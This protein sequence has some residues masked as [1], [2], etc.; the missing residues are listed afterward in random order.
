MRITPLT[1]LV[2]GST[3]KGLAAKTMAGGALVLLATLALGQAITIDKNGNNVTNG[4]NAPVDRRYA[5]IKPT[6]VALPAGE[7]NAKTKL[8]LIR[9]LQADRGFAMRPFP[10]GHKGL[11]LEANGKMAPTGEAYQAMVVNEGLSAK[12]GE[13]LLITDVKVEKSRIILQLNGGPDPKHRFLRHIQI[14]TGPMMNPAV[15]DPGQEPIGSRLTLTFK[16]HVPDLTGK[17][18]EALLEP[19]ISFQV[20]TPLQAFTDTLPPQLK[21]AILDH[22]VLVG[23]STDMVLFA[24][25]QPRKKVR[26]MDGQMPFEE[27]IYGLP[28]EDVEFVRINGNRVIRVEVAKVG[29]PPQIF[30]KDEVEG[31]MRTDGT[32]LEPARERERKVEM[33]DVKRDPD[34]QAPAA[35]PSLRVP[36]ETTT[37]DSPNTGTSNG[38]VGV[39]KPVQF[40]E[41]KPDD[42]PVAHHDEPA[43]ETPPADTK[44]AP[45]PAPADKPREGTQPAQPTPPPTNQP[46]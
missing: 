6:T 39:M 42:H 44:D 10:K 38:R 45:A 36:G 8:E 2:P 13:R 15:Q 43:P 19:L 40:P 12:P 17:Q 23:M 4:Q 21:A 25:G 7:I 41:Q 3:R 34:T 28:P 32:P 22:T 5:P 30:D 1:G 11:M 18:V 9:Y 26:E 24:K 31:L 20:K 46:Q 14:G 37:V 29:K 27:W 35:P 33:G 16:D